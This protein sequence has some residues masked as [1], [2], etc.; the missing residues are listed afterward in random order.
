MSDWNQTL[1]QDPWSLLTFSALALSIVFQR[2]WPASLRWKALVLLATAVAFIQARITW[3]GLGLLAAI[4]LCLFAY[5]R[6]KEIRP[7]SRGIAALTSFTL[8]LIVC[9]RLLPA[10][11]NWQLTSDLQ[12]STDGIAYSLWLN[13]DKPLIGFILCLFVSSRKSFLQIT[14]KQFFFTVQLTLG[15][16]VLLG[17]V[18]VG[19]GYV[20]WDPKLPEIFG[21]WA[22]RNLF[23]TCFGEELIFRGFVQAELEQALGPPLALFTTALLFGFC[24]L[25]G[26]WAYV[27]F[28]SIAGILYGFVFQ[29]TKSLDLA[30]LAHALINTL[31][32]L[33]FTYPALRP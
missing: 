17:L 4:F 25:G 18:A 31:H 1:L 23:I 30:I 22:V 33:F 26:G 12:V 3:L 27:I 29:K 2:L 9:A 10:F 24:H 28:A 6:R 8:I 7:L 21:I 5:Y 19:V 20:K 15:V 11:Q 16:A 32:F 13:L 14:Q